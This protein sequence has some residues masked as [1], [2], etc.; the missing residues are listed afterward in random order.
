MEERQKRFVVIG[1]AIPRRRAYRTLAE[2]TTARLSGADQTDPAPKMG[3][4]VEFYRSPARRPWTPAGV[5]APEYGKPAQVWWQNV[6][7]GVTGEATHQQA[8]DGPTRYQDAIRTR[9]E[10]SGAQGKLGPK[11]N[12]ERDPE[13]LVLQGREGRQSRA[14]AQARQ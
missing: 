9:L 5:N 2:N 10:K 11:L 8:M 6:S 3:G 4:W 14:P 7:K 13:I 1:P 12:E